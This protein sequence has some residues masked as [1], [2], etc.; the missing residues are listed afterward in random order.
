MSRRSKP[1]AREIFPDVRYNSVN[2]QNF[3][4]RVF[5]SG[6]KSV[7]AAEVYGAFD[8]IE[9]RT[10]R[11]IDVREVFVMNQRYTFVHVFG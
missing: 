1:E 5:R 10:K 3:I 2:V 4:N 9:E 7:A 11:R 6:K 8:L